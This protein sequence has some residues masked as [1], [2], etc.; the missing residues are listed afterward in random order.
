MVLIQK[1]NLV[2]LFD[3]AWCA[4]YDSSESMFALRGIIFYL[5]KNEL[6]R[7]LGMYL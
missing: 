7:A 4:T 1:K 6:F 2:L 3:M 5:G